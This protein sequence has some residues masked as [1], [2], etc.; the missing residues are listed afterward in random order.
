MSVIDQSLGND[1]TLFGEMIV[2]Q[3]NQIEDPITIRRFTSQDTTPGVFK[4]AQKAAYTDFPSSALVVT[5]DV[6]KS[7]FAEGIM[8]AGDLVLEMR[9][10]LSEAS[11][12]I[13]GTAGGDRVIWRG[14]EYRMVQRP[15]PINLGGDVFF[16]TLLR[17]TNAQTD[18]VGA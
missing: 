9:D 6:A 8:S 18:T 2:E 12:N 3:E 10:R 14:A 1:A 17:R 5:L 13:G 15:Q 4:T 7:M 16:V 11:G